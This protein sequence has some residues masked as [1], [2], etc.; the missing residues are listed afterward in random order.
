M[1]TL[2]LLKKSTAEKKFFKDIENVLLIVSV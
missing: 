2:Y 1:L